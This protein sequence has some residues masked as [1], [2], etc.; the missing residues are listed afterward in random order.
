MENM[1]HEY[2]K[3][4]DEIIY[5]ACVEISKNIKN[6]L[7][8]TDQINKFKS[9]KITYKTILMNI[10]EFIE[11]YYGDDYYKI[12]LSTE[13]DAEKLKNVYE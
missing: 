1:Q 3:D 4:A 6:K 9:N 10:I 2:I 12:R 8:I 7:G 13:S 5:I 11:D